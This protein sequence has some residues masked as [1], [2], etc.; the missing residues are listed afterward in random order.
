MKSIKFPVSVIQTGFDLCRRIIPFL[1]RCPR[2]E[3]DLAELFQC[4]RSPEE[5]LLLEH[6]ADCAGGIENIDPIAIFLLGPPAGDKGDNSRSWAEKNLGQSRMSRHLTN[7]W[8]IK[9]RRRGRGRG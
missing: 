1:R 6:S 7:S 9:R 2:I 4:H 5:L 3:E 8:N